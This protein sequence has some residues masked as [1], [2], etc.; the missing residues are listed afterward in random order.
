M[1][2]PTSV[3]VY[4][5]FALSALRFNATVKMVL[6]TDWQATSTQSYSFQNFYSINPHQAQLRHMKQ[7][8]RTDY[9]AFPVLGKE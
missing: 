3:H 8:L 1:M 4:E 5:E 2:L 7:P 9:A 6:Q